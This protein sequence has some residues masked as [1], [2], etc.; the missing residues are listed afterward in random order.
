MNGAFARPVLPAGLLGMRRLG[1]VDTLSEASFATSDSCASTEKACDEPTAEIAGSGGGGNTAAR[2][3]KMMSAKSESAPGT[4]DPAA[5]AAAA[6]RRA[7]RRPVLFCSTLDKPRLPAQ[8][9][10]ARSSGAAHSDLSRLLATADD[11]NS[12][13]LGGGSDSSAAQSAA[14]SVSGE[15]PR[16][17]IARTKSYV[18]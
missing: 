15:Q 10:S 14:G 17:R 13:L 7:R 4:S 9:V 5:A 11:I 1:S 6:L 12:M 2:R 18:F 3:A 16:S 8:A